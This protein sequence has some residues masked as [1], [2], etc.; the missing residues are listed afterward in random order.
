MDDLSTIQLIHPDPSKKLPRISREKY[1]LI[2]TAILQLIPDD[3]PGFPFSSLPDAIASLLTPEQLANMGSVS[4]YTVSVKLHLEGLGV[5]ERIPGV[6][7][8]RLRRMR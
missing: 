8:Q 1:E 4:W 3:E 7:P 5:I 6:S 2:K